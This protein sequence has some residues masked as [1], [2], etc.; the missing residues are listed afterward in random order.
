[1]CGNG[2]GADEC[3]ECGQCR[4]AQIAPECAGRLRDAPITQRTRAADPPGAI[5]C[6]VCGCLTNLC[7]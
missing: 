3:G 7:Y 6:K 5:S 1:M 2:R 4:F